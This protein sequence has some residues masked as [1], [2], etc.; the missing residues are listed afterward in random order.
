MVWGE[1]KLAFAEFL[2]VTG[3]VLNSASP[4]S[5]QVGIA[6]KADLPALP[7]SI[8]FPSWKKPPYTNKQTNTGPR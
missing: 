6:G 1:E 7:I 5:S 3:A 8:H 4:F 2:L